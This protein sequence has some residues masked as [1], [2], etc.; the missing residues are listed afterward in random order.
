MKGF[1]ELLKTTVEI[2]MRCIILTVILYTIYI[3][4]NS[5]ARVVGV[6]GI[7]WLL[8]PLYDYIMKIRAASK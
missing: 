6:I 7:F 5:T 4:G 1:I 2:F 8:T 3:P